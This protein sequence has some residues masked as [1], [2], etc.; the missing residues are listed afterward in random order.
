MPSPLPKS[1]IWGLA[2][3]SFLGFADASYLTAEHYLKLPLPC[4]ITQGCDTVLNSRYAMLA[5]LPIAFFGA[6]YYLLLLFLAVSLLTNKNSS[7]APQ[8]KAA[9]ALSSFGLLVSIMLVYLQFFVIY[10]LCLYCLASATFTLIA[11][12]LSISIYRALKKSILSHG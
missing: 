1:K 3:A 4:S 8:I 2:I 9:L 7:G 12:V 11:F 10:Q 5:G 6:I